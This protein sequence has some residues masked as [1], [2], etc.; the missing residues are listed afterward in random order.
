MECFWRLGLWNVRCDDRGPYIDL[1]T[2]NHSHWCFA[3]PHKTDTIKGPY[4]VFQDLKKMREVKVST[5]VDGSHLLHAVCYYFHHENNFWFCL[6]F[7]T[8]NWNFAISKDLLTFLIFF[9]VPMRG[10]EI[11]FV[12]WV[13]SRFY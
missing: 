4:T 13:S 1:R 12:L 8:R 11:Y 3:N 10:Y 5:F 7:P 6:S 2:S 9:Y